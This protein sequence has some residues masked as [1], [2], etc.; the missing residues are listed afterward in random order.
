[1]G[2]FRV[3]TNSLLNKVLEL[4]KI[5]SFYIE[6]P[7]LLTFSALGQILSFSTNIDLPEGKVISVESF[8]FNGKAFKVLIDGEEYKGNLRL[9]RAVG[10]EPL[11]M[12]YLIALN[13]GSPSIQPRKHE[14]KDVLDLWL[15]ENNK[16]VLPNKF[17]DLQDCLVIPTIVNG[18]PDN[19]EL[20]LLNEY[21]DD[22]NV[23]KVEYRNG[24]I[25]VSRPST[26]EAY[27]VLLEE[28]Q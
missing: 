15:T 5:Q 9:T 1:M 18:D 24:T 3:N 10:I 27:A 6:E 4:E 22:K 11:S 13:F 16:L 20:L 25:K 19:L 21:D 7:T 2:R 23:L 12:L 26:G 14:G 8:E 28:L 17:V